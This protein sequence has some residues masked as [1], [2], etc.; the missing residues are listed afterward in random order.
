MRAHDNPYTP[1][2]GARPPALVGRDAE[3][4]AFEVL[5]DR[6]RAGHTEQSM[7]ITGLRGVGK[8]VLLVTHDVD[9][10]LLLSTRVILMA[11]PP[12]RVAE[13]IALPPGGVAETEFGPL[14]AH[15]LQ[16]LDA[17]TPATA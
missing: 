12:G 4:V 2:A 7:L 17:L 8:T 3:L 6:M 14:R 10:A 15:I 1:N 9:E 13:D 11:G 16:R 5:L